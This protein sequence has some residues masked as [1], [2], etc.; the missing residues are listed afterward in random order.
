MDTR[1]QI[2]WENPFNFK[3]YTQLIYSIIKFENKKYT[4]LYKTFRNVTSHIYSF[5]TKFLKN[6]SQKKNEE[7]YKR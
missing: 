1:K 4:S 2:L 3:F 5:K 6:M 7:I